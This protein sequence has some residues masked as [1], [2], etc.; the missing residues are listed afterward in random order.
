MSNNEIKDILARALEQTKQ[1]QFATA[2][3][4]LEAGV[5]KFPEDVSLWRALSITYQKQGAMTDAISALEKLIS[6]EKSDV[7]AWVM[8]GA[9]HENAKEFRE[10]LQAYHCALALND[11]NPSPNQREIAQ[12]QSRIP[13]VMKEIEA[14]LDRNLAEAGLKTDNT[15]RRFNTAVEIMFGRKQIYFQQ[16]QH[17][18]FPEL[19][20]RQF[21]AP[22]E[23]DWIPNLEAQW[24]YIRKELEA[25]LA[26]DQFFAPYLQSEAHIPG[27]DGMSLANSMDWSSFY[28]I[29]DGVDVTEN[30]S[31]CP[32]T[33]KAVKALDLCKTGGG[34]PSVLFSRLKPGAHIPPH[35]GM[36]NMRLI[37]HL[38]IIVP[39]KSE[40]RVGN[41]MHEWAEGKVVVFDD[42]IEHEAWNHADEDRFVLLFDIWRP[43]ITE[44]ERTLL[45]IVI[46]AR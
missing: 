40:L 12:V 6:V 21:Y 24:R 4:S 9:L 28:L 23:F 38:P 44:R 19:P 14:R 20:H 27:S 30:Q 7:K 2:Q 39:G 42:T 29:K 31:R 34:T 10:A 37:C 3:K 36:L 16:P 41:E 1:N 33:T 17:L 43:E 15:D 45:D 22:E 26:D 25:L 18:Y 35:T 11:A 5:E 32:L 13:I 46:S 8:K